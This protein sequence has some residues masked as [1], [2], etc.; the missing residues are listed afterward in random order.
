MKSSWFACGALLLFSVSDAQA[1]FYVGP[2]Q[3]QYYDITFQNVVI[4]QMVAVDDGSSASINGFAA[5]QEYWWWNPA[6]GNAWRGAFHLV[7]ANSGFHYADK[8]W[9]EYDFG[10]FDLSSPVPIPAVNLTTDDHFYEVI[11]VDESTTPPTE[12]TV[13]YFWL[14]GGAGGQ[15][16]WY[17]LDGILANDLIGVGADSV[18]LRALSVPPGAGS[19]NIIDIG[20][21]PTGH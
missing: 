5:G 15:Q 12:E 6:H 16:V 3:I 10:R 20:P 19:L 4:G 11:E 17:G 9:E 18:L 8:A 13:A 2:S 1:Q 21:Y 7:P 14:D